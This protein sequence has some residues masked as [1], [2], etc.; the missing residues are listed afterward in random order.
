MPTLT[1]RST[2]RHPRWSIVG[3]IAVVGVF[4]TSC[5]VAHPAAARSPDPSTRSSPT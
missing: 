2:P 3:G 4:G 5:Q 1:S